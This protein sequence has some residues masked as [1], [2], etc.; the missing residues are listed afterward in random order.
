MVIDTAKLIRK[1]LE[2]FSQGRLEKP[3]RCELCKRKGY[4]NWHGKYWRKVM[5]LSG[6][7]NIPIKRLRCKE[8]GGTFPLLPIFILK[9]RRYGVDVILLALEEEER[10]TRE[11]VV[12]ELCQN[13]G[14]VLDALTV[15]LWKKRISG[16]TLRKLKKL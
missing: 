11:K 13:Y 6:E 16:A 7:R 4:L 12:S 15:W 1:Y 2:D 5:T 9:Y 10:K 8:C 3:E 14:L